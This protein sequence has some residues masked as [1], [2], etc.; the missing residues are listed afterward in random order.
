MTIIWKKVKKHFIL[1][2]FA[3]DNYMESLLD[4][5][6]YNRTDNILISYYLGTLYPFA[7]HCFI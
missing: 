2:V 7:Y 5:N 4:Q 1:I 3:L 6:S